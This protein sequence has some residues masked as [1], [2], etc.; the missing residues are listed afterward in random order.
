MRAGR[1]LQLPGQL[2]A[3]S[4]S[5]GVP[6]CVMGGNHRGGGGLMLKQNVYSIVVD[7]FVEKNSWST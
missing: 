5:V 4:G 6:V 2:G 1:R 7:C 3:V